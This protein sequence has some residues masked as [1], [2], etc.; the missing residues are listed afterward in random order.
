[1]YERSG[2]LM[3]K[4]IRSL[5]RRAKNGDSEAFGDLYEIYALDM[6]KFA[7]YFMHNEQDALDAV[8]N[9]CV[10]AYSSIVSLKD[11]NAFKSWLF[12]ILSN[13]CKSSLTSAQAKNEC[14]TAD[15]DVP[16]V[17]SGQDGDFT[18][19]TEIYDAM[20]SL[21][22][23]ERTVVILSVVHRYKSSEIAE[24]INCPASTVRSKLSRSLSKLRTILT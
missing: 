9:A 20:E 22:D 18:L 7:L 19:R 3:K 21:T 5:V 14:K 2:T 6:Y 17:M 1:M 12:K 11:P 10:K 4:D 16:V 13:I 8:Q 15:G 23:E 24:I